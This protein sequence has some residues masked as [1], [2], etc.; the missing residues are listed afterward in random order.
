MNLAVILG[1]LLGKVIIPELI[2]YT[3]RKFE[4]TGQWPTPEELKARIFDTNQTTITEADQILLR[5]ALN[6]HPVP[7]AEN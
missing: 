2:E 6:P 1:E 7:P 4:E 3:K 5:L